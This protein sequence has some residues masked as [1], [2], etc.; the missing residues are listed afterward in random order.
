MPILKITEDYR[1]HVTATYALYEPVTCA[2]K[3]VRKTQ[4]YSSQG[5]KREIHIVFVRLNGVK[6]VKMK[7]EVAIMRTYCETEI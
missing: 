4:V 6:T 1:S 7:L 5:V 3:A 2:R